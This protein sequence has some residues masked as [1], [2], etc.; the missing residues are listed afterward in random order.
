MRL[1]NLPHSSFAWIALLLLSLTAIITFLSAQHIAGLPPCSLCYWQRY[2]WYG[3]C[4]L[5]I[6]GL[7]MPF[8]RILFWFIAIMLLFATGGIGVFHAG[9]E[10]GFWQGLSTCASNLPRI[11]NIEELKAILLA[12]PSVTCDSAPWHFLGIS[13]AGYNAI[14]S[15]SI[16]STMFFSW[17]FTAKASV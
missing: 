14:L 3:L 6:L 13:M 7:F 4:A 9:V 17:L 5:S 11:D 12:K 16:G 2:P 15:L 1:L 8:L 10:Y